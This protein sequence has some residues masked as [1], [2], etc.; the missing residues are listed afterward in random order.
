MKLFPLNLKNK[1][2]LE[3]IGKNVCH[4]SLNQCAVST[5]LYSANYWEMAKDG[6]TVLAL[7]TTQLGLC[8]FPVGAFEET[9]LRR[10][11]ADRV[12]VDISEGMT[13]LSVE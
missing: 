3:E 5:Y 10:R 7:P 4:H 2:K 8:P 1:L 6:V 12:A 9:P 13:A 11:V